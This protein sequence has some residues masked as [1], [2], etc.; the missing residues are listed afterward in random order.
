MARFVVAQADDT[1]SGDVLVQGLDT[2]IGDE[3][4]GDVGVAEDHG[5]GMPQLDFDTYGSQLFW[6]AV[7]FVVL[8]L[9][10]S[11]AALPRIA[12]AIE[13]RRDRIASDLD[14]AARLK[15][16][17][18]GVI[19]TYEA[20]LAEA[21][22]KAHQIATETRDRLNQQLA[23]ERAE[24]EHRLTE[25]TEAAERHVAE[26]KAKAL[27]EVDGAAADA[28]A[29]IVDLLIGSRPSEAETAEAVKAVRS[30]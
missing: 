2:E 9:I 28:T 6:L 24:I 21:R 4:Q 8:Y 15:E 16:E 17:T 3:I 22:A 26:V 20:E 27:A 10:M 30:S 18:D 19:A 13:S 5:G 14:T 29:E 12:A 11:R 25:R 23:E 1:Q 7:S